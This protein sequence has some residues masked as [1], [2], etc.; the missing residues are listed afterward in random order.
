MDMTPKELEEEAERSLDTIIKL[1]KREILSKGYSKE[2]TI[3]R[4]IYILNAANSLNRPVNHL[5]ALAIHRLA[6][7]DREKALCE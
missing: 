7:I 5:L 4:L 3:N 1:Y 2:E 6:T